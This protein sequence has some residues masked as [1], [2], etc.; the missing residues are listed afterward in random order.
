[1][2]K[3]KKK[4]IG[5][6]ATLTEI[7]M[8]LIEC[9]SGHNSGAYQFCQNLLDVSACLQ[10]EH[11][12]SAELRKLPICITKLLIFEEQGQTDQKYLSVQQH[13]CAVLTDKLILPASSGKW[14]VLLDTLVSLLFGQDIKERA[15]C[16]CE[17]QKACNV[18]LN[19]EIIHY[20][21]QLARESNNYY[22][23]S[24]PTAQVQNSDWLSLINH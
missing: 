13:W 5:H 21:R 2:V 14:Q 4:V 7:S 17:T 1:M 15:K 10:M 20:T 12:S 19:A 16:I 9:I 8:H 24:K 11:A 18:R 23:N 22:F 6:F 3:F